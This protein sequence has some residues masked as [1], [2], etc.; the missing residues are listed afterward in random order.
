MLPDFHSEF[1]LPP[2]W[3]LHFVMFS[4]FPLEENPNFYQFIEYN[5]DVYY[6]HMN[7]AKF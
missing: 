2:R 4:T 5:H 6:I 1:R 3:T 7:D